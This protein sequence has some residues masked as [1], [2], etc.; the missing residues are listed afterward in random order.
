MSA[1][2]Q[3]TVRNAGLLLMQRGVNATGGLLFAVLIPRLMG[4]EVYGQY[5]LVTS[6]SIWFVLFSGLGFTPVI[7]RYVPQFTCQGDRQGL[8][9]LF[10]VVSLSEIGAVWRA[11][12]PSRGE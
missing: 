6:L 4:P 5:A 1:K 12:G 9:A 10:R 3:I 11:V 8:Q 7:G 2:A